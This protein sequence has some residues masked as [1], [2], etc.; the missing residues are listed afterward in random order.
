M[1]TNFRTFSPTANCLKNRIIAISGAGAGIG[2]VLAT[3]L[4]AYGATIILMGRTVEKLETVYDEIE[5]AGYPQ[6]AIIPIDFSNT[7]EAEYE[8]ITA[9]IEN[10][11]GKL[12]GLI[13]NA[14][15]LGERIPISNYPMKVWEAVMIVNVNAPFALSKHLLPLLKKSD[16]GSIAFTSSSVGRQGRAYWGAYAA[17]KA[18]L[19][20]LMQTLADELEE[21][22]NIRVNSIDPGATRTDMRALAY[23]AENPSTVK[24]PESLV[25]LFL[26]CMAD[27]SIGTTGQQ[28]SYS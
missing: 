9:N 8:N 5:Q 23:P 7:T 28:L 20:N 18:A 17:S 2:R 22:S 12:D 13:H 3:Q 6:A 11:F 27:D 21:T 24:D 10:E 25:P 15:L 4:A 1:S 16:H 14:A 26:Y 19:E